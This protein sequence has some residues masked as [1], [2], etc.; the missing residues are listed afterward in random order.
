MYNTTDKGVK[1]VVSSNILQSNKIKKE[2][3][4][5]FVRALSTAFDIDYDLSHNICSEQ[6]NRQNRKGTKN[7]QIH[8]FF[9]SHPIING[10]IPNYIDSKEITYPGSLTHQGK[11]KGACKITVKMFLEKYPIGTYLVLINKHAFTIKDGV[12]IG[13]KTDAKRMRAKIMDVIEVKKIL[14]AIKVESIKT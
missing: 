9:S 12:V 3:N 4:D 2:T 6:L 7:F 8:Q 11:G 5:C 13:N 1:Y 10:K 14:D